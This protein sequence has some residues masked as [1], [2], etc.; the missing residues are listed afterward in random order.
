MKEITLKLTIDE[1]N[2]VLESLGNMPFAKV[3]VLIEKIQNQAEKQLKNGQ[4][5]EEA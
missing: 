5:E 3:H 1:A 2:L 4:S